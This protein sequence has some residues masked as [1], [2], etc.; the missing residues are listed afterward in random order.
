MEKRT[1]RQT[2]TREY[3]LPYKK[4]KESKAR[5]YY[6][7]SGRKLYPWQQLIL[8]DI[9]AVNDD[10][11]WT[12]QS[13]GLAVPRQNGKNE[14]IAVRELYGLFAGEKI[15]HTAH[16]T[17]TSRAAWE[18]LCHI[19]AEMGYVE[20]GRLSAKEKPP[21]KSYKTNK[22]H[23][24]ESIKLT[25]G[26]E[27]NFRTRSNS[28][29]LGESYDLLVIDE[30][31]EY[32][33]IQRSALIYTI[34]A[35]ENPQ[36]IYTGT[37]P[38]ATSA[39]T[40]FLHLRY[41]TLAGEAYDT[42]WA[43]WSLANYTKDIR[44]NDLWYETNPSLG[45]RLQERTI[46]SEIS[47][48]DE[49]DFNVQRLGVWLQYNQKS[50]ITEDMWDQLKCEK[51]PDFKGKI[52]AG[53][54]YSKVLDTVALSIALKTK[55]GKIF[56]ESIDVRPIRAGDTWLIDFLKHK[57]IREIII[58]G[59]SGQDRLKDELKDAQV[60]TK[61]ILP[62]VNEIIKAHGIFEQ[63][64]YKE[65]LTHAG[66]TSLRNAAT[67]C[68]KRPIGSAGGWGYK[69]LIEGVDIALLDSAVLAY[70]AAAEAKEER[71]QKIFY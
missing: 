69:S 28:G 41:E 49:A 25:G 21:E 27:I 50:V 11:L 71:K 58:D 7:Q 18:R 51:L 10:G 60:K 39:G 55:E 2:P 24:L 4:T 1:G 20:L 53:I 42:G 12:H 40:V 33:N 63:A 8:S 56:V 70:W 44:N 6:E 62:K 31:Q 66:Q 36:T 57:N 35:S 37:P 3:I 65:T 19:L 38:T 23:G 48:A 47:D 52:F 13:F 61:V 15:C 30:A 43:E 34:A 5:K 67:N 46:R 14:I 17:T 45:H 29:G 9:C 64:I 32:T 68:E 22:A 26:G 16:R 59:A 54:K